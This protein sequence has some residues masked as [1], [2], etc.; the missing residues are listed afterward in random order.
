MLS[1][2]SSADHIASG[3]RETAAAIQRADDDVGRTLIAAGDA[4]D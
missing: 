1:G 2:A 4:T 3:D